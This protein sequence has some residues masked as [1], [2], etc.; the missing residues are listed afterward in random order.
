MPPPPP[1]RRDQQAYLVLKV[2]VAG[3][4]V[5]EHQAELGE[6][7]V[8]VVVVQLDQPVPLVL[9]VAPLGARQQEVGEVGGGGQVDGGVKV[10]DD[11]ARLVPLAAEHQVAHPDVAVAD[12]PKP[13][14]DGSVYTCVVKNLTLNFTSKKTLKKRVKN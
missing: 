4:E 12:G 10:E 8:E 5:P 7:R 14:Q 6:V 3:A 13:G 9:Q 11:G 1:P 2:R